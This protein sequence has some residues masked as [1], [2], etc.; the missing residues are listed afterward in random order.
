LPDLRWYD[1][2]IASFPCNIS[3]D[4]V[5]GG[6]GHLTP[7]DVRDS[8]AFLREL[9]S[10]FPGICFDSAVD[11]GAGVGR[12]TKNLLLQNC[13]TVTLVEQSP[14]L[15][16]AA[17]DYLGPIDEEKSVIYVQQGLQVSISIISPLL[18]KYS[19]SF[20]EFCPEE[21]SYD[22]IWIQVLFQAQSFSFLLKLNFIVGNWSSK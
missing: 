12:V 16:A 18:S 13:R 22:L 15:L 17:R 8:N 7:V 6:F 4:G 9:R 10:D 11:C 20:Q 3:L 21:N 2:F 5:L 19:G 1:S 14:R